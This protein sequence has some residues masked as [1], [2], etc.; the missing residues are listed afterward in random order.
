MTKDSL[1]KGTLILGLAALVARVLGAIQRIPLVHLLGDAGMASYAIAFNIY[2]IL[3]VIAT[4][5][6]PS[7]L[8]KLVSERTALGQHAEA[9][10]IYKA[11]MR[12]ALIAGLIM[13]LLLFVAA[14]YYAQ[15]AEDPDSTAAIQAI[16]PALLLF[17]LIAIMR[18]YFQGRQHMLPNG[19]SQIV[20]QVLRL[21][22]AVGLAY[23]FL[24]LGYRMEIAVAGASFGGV[25][26]S[27]GALAVMIYFA[28][29]MRSADRRAALMASAGSTLATDP[30]SSTAPT[31]STVTSAGLD[32]TGTVSDTG[33]ESARKLKYSQIYAM[34][35]RISIPIVIFSMTVPLIYAIDSSIVIPLLKEQLGAEQAKETLGLLGGRAQALAGIPIILA[36]A[37]SQSIVPIVSAAYARGDKQQLRR[38]ASKALQLSILT[39]MPAVIAICA[40]AR[41]INITM[42]DDDLGTSIIIM[43]TLSAIFQ[44]VMQTSGSILMGLG[45]MRILIVFVIMGITIKVVGSILLAPKFGIYGIIAA[46]MLCFIVMGQFHLHALRKLVSYVILGKKWMG[47][48]I[49]S[50]VAATAGFAIEHGLHEYVQVLG[51]R[52]SALFHAILAGGVVAVLYVLLLILLRVITADDVQSLPSPLRKVLGRLVK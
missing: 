29:K 43:L 21:L 51:Y 47:F 22:A 20:E 49:A 41:S 33:V 5:G 12:F 37:L 44:I 6:I 25:M 28:W 1:I 26:G 50:F 27:V 48:I 18:G 30:M 52:W 16:A 10:Q 45:K 4:A 46:T 39:G 17:P 13:S 34:I 14:P 36:I 35:F 15:W 3:L 7:A 31:S 19:L 24:K 40:A 38:Q 9:N 11:S 23:L 32:R 8:S 42:F 2:S